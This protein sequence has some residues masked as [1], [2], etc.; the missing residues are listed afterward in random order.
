M[1]YYTAVVMDKWALCN[2]EDLSAWADICSSD[3]VYTK[4]LQI[5]GP[6]IESR[7]VINYLGKKKHKNKKDLLLRLPHMRPE[8]LMVMVINS[9][10][11]GMWCQ[12]GNSVREKCDAGMKGDKTVYEHITLTV[13]CICASVVAV[14]KLL[15]ILSVCM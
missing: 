1:Y 5:D 10:S 11:S 4:N 8:M 13:R 3:T 14:E 2:G 6:G 9:V 12:T 15:H 7:L